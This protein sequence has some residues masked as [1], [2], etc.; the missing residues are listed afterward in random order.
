MRKQP[1][2]SYNPWNWKAEVGE[3][4]YRYCGSGVTIAFMFDLRESRGRNK[5]AAGE[6]TPHSVKK[7]GQL[8][9]AINIDD[10]WYWCD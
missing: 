7:N 8:R 6:L 4:V 3:R 9:L 10:I 2:A 5:A 1:V